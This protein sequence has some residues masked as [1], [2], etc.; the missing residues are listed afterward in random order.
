MLTRR[1]LLKGTVAMLAAPAEV[2]IF[3]NVALQ[4]FDFESA[5]VDGWTTVEGTWAVEEMDGAPSGRKVL[6]QRATGNAFNVIV[7]SPGP[8][9]DVD[10]S[11]KFK[12]MS[13]REDASGGLVVRF[14]GGWYYV[15]RANAREDNVRLYHFDGERHQ[16]ATAGVKSPNLG[17]WHLLRVLAVGD[18]LQ[19]WLDGQLLLDHRDTRSR[20]GRVGLWTKADSIT[21][22][23]DLSIRGS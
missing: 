18:H 23:D 8:F 3:D 19:A 2:K 7:A 14:D 1:A 22:F 11:V 17:Q 13:G 16:L 10:A 6:V 20:V 12:P 4:R 9:S 5:G 15:V 21:A